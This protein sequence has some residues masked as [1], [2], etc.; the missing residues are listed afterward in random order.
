M[1]YL[2]EKWVDW[3]S[4]SIGAVL[5]LITAMFTNTLSPD[6]TLM[7]DMFPELDK[8][9]VTIQIIAGTLLMGI[10]IFQLVRVMMGEISGSRDTVFKL[11]TRS[12]IF[13]F[14]IFYAPQIMNEVLTFAK[15]S[16][17]LMSN[18]TTG[19]EPI[20]FTSVSSGMTTLGTGIQS[21][22][23]LSYTGLT[24][25]AG[26]IVNVILMVFVGWNYIK[27]LI[28]IVER[29]ILLGVMYFSSPLAFATGGSE[30]TNSIFA[31]WCKMLGSQLLLMIINIW[32]LR[33]VNSGLGR[34]I[35]VA[36]ASYL[37]LYSGSKTLLLVGIASL[38]RIGQRMDSYFAAL[39]INT[40]QTGQGLAADL[41]A[42]AIT[43]KTAASGLSN[44]AFGRGGIS[45]RLSSAMAG[46]NSGAVTASKAMYANSGAGG[47]KINGGLHEA[48]KVKKAYNQMAAG[49]MSN[50]AKDAVMEGFNGQNRG[51]IKDSL[52][53]S[54]MATLAPGLA[55]QSA[56]VM[57]G[58]ETSSIQGAEVKSAKGKLLEPGNNGKQIGPNP[59]GQIQAENVSNSGIKN[60]SK[61]LKG[62]PQFSNIVPG[63]GGV[64]GTVS[65]NGINTNFAMSRKMPANGLYD[66]KTTLADGSTGY[67]SYG[68]KGAVLSMAEYG[69]GSQIIDGKPQSFE[70]LT[71]EQAKD[72][73]AN[74][75][76]LNTTQ[77]GSVQL[78][79]DGQ[80]LMDRADGTGFDQIMPLGATLGS[81]DYDG[82]IFTGKNDGLAYGVQPYSGVGFRDIDGTM[83]DNTNPNSEIYMNDTPLVEHLNDTY[84]F[85]SPVEMASPHWDE[86]NVLDYIQVVS[87]NGEMA[88][89]HESRFV[90]H[91][92]EYGTFSPVNRKADIEDE[93]FEDMTLCVEKANKDRSFTGSFIKRSK[94]L[95]YEEYEEKQEVQ[96]KKKKETS[97][98]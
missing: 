11:I 29:Y 36:W 92:N 9:G 38:L 82:E 51:A 13:M 47:A 56:K 43:V 8:L 5:N 24:M 14:F 46:D 12:M 96:P 35:G 97:D 73:L 88:R 26:P 39:G 71:G 42:T 65:V 64:T 37:P 74:F 2:I 22:S 23:T 31:S 81:A 84:A 80:L 69:K 95:Q 85:Q 89:L 25:D 61:N 32:I 44:V 6:M 16:Y 60:A 49:K 19:A 15:T 75:E 1:G 76:G 90:E 45:N 33:V 59:S 86:D 83:L 57:S 79:N 52:A 62:V 91:S 34:F 58:K 66:Q 50:G 94:Q 55:K 78:G 53:N 21:G 41:A 93:T 7:R 3:M 27:L 98:D 28:E 87:E 68:D 30:A 10:L 54:Y 72:T 40:A 20:D 17:D 70:T 4:D 18:A 48:G 77:Y 63:G 67:I